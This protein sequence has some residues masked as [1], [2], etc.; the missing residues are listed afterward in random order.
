MVESPP[1]GSRV[2]QALV[3]FTI[4]ADNQFERGMIELG[5]PGMRT[6]LIMWAGVMRYVPLEGVGLDDLVRRCGL[7]ADAVKFAVGGLQRW[8]YLH[9]LDQGE[10]APTSASGRGKTARLTEAGLES[11]HRS[12]K[13]DDEIIQ[14]WRLVHGASVDQLDDTLTE[15]IS[16]RDEHG[17]VLGRGLAPAPT[18][19]RANAPYKSQTKRLV[20]DPASALPHHPMPVR[21]GAWP[22]GA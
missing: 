8:G 21:Q 11:V 18:S 13:I 4:E 7:T 3:A 9:Q 1:L 22:D 6:S 20:A 14:G 5:R 16:R 19:W 15:L 12:A 2:S 17:S 10:L